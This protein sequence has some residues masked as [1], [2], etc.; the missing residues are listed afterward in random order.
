MYTRSTNVLITMMMLAVILLVWTRATEAAL[1]VSQRAYELDA[2]LVERWP[3]GDVGTIVFREC[4][5]CEQVIVKV[6]AAT[7]YRLSMRGANVGRDELLRV[8]ATLTDPSDADV[9]IFYRTADDTATRI[10]LDAD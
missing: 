2:S 8:K 1:E 4:D 9:Y 5:G 6:D 3:L 7:D 10:V